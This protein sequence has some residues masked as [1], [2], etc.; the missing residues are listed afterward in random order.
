MS[1]DQFADQERQAHKKAMQ[2][3]LTK[4]EEITEGMSAD[5]I[6]TMVNRLQAAAPTQQTNCEH[7]GQPLP[8]GAETY[9]SP[10]CQ[11]LDKASSQTS[12]V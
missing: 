9:C 3:L 6:E 1:E 2:N 7:C 5:E 12:K 10:Q 11:T 8:A 4:V